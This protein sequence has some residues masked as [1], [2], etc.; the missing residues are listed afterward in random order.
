MTERS[1]G[2]SPTGVIF[3]V[4]LVAVLGYFLVGKEIFIP[5]HPS[6]SFLV[7]SLTVVGAFNIL[8]FRGKAEFRLLVLVVTAL[9]AATWFL[10]LSFE[11]TFRGLGRFWLVAILAAA[12][13]VLLSARRVI[14]FR[15]SGTVVWIFL[16][17]LFYV[18]MMA[19]DMYVFRLYPSGERAF[20]EQYLVNA[21]RLGLI[22]GA[23]IGVGFDIGRFFG[24]RI[25][26][27]PTQSDSTH[28]SA[29]P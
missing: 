21:A 6:F 2:V 18:A 14:A 28:P 11:S 27:P 19:L 12:G 22:L 1:G 13:S 20:V 17:M 24:P 26:A 15:F 5:R 4:V 25:P 23:G 29:L 8:F 9:L 10:T 7:L 3:E 16:G